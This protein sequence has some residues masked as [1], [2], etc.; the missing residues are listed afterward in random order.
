MYTNLFLCF[1]LLLTFRKYMR[2]GSY[3]MTFPRRVAFQ[4]SNFLSTKHPNPTC[5][6]FAVS[7]CPFCL[8][9][10]IQLIRAMAL[11]A[12]LLDN[13]FPDGLSFSVR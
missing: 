13:H 11:S 2:G 10:Y 6:Y 12:C 5:E 1:C 3:A 9:L 4:N 8:F 7:G